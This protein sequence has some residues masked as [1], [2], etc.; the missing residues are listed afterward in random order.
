VNEERAM[1][2][3]QLP[4]PNVLVPAEA[5]ADRGAV[6]DELERLIGNPGG[7]QSV[8]VFGQPRVG[9][10]SLVRHVTQRWVDDDP[11]ARAALMIDCM[12][13][14]R[15][16]HGQVGISLLSRMVESL[17]GDLQAKAAEMGVDLPEY[18]RDLIEAFRQ[19]VRA[20][21][22]GPGHPANV[23]GEARRVFGRLCEATGVTA[24][25]VL[26]EFDEMSGRFDGAVG[27][28]PAWMGDYTNRLSLVVVSRRRVVD[29]EE[30]SAPGSGWGRNF[31]S[32]LS[33]GMFDE[34]AVGQLVA[35][36]VRQRG[37]TRDVDAA[38]DAVRIRATMASSIG[39]HPLLVAVF[40]SGY[41]E[42]PASADAIAV[43]LRDARAQA[44]D[45]FQQVVNRFEL[46]GLLADLLAHLFATQRQVRP[47]A[48]IRLRQYELVLPG[49]VPMSPD[50]MSFLRAE[51]RSAL[52]RE[53]E[54]YVR[55]RSALERL[56]R[57]RTPGLVDGLPAPLARRIREEFE[58]ERHRQTEVIGVEHDDWCS[59]LL[60]TDAVEV[61]ASLDVAGEGGLVPI[62]ANLIE[63][64]SGCAAMVMERLADL[65]LALTPAG[66]AA[67]TH[68]PAFTDRHRETLAGLAARLEA[69][70]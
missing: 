47:A 50:F 23:A 12:E 65:H 26:D 9:K 55:F 64:V 21:D 48:V 29:I 35:V 11:R 13:L 62:D 44:R 38:G 30:Q 58:P 18:H 43:G 46:D 34:E 14:E 70:L 69:L 22:R 52:Q 8:A 51:L 3:T 60:V 54:E 10:T 28:I 68:R 17:Y 16:P 7:P 63:G 20:A 56:V 25:V 53:S 42:A 67:P 32:H 4:T 40:L 61:L 66:A 27:S 41:A 45:L 19:E 49:A 39:H 31:R 37:G 33:V 36:A 59:V 2:P 24:L 15:V 5:F 6:Q 57:V 1:A